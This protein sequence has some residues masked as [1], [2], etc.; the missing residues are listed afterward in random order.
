M[1]GGTWRALNAGLPDLVVNAVAIDRRT[2]TTVY[3]G[4][5]AGAFVLQQTTGSETTTV[6]F[7]TPAPECWDSAFQGID[8]GLGQWQISG[9]YNVNPTNHIYFADSTGTSRSFQ[10]TS[11]PRVLKPNSSFICRCTGTTTS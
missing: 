9:P 11:A 2:P 5:R 1:G 6:N 3:T 8:F 7:D 4:A 10:F